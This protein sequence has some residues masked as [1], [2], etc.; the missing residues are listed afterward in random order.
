M[1]Y[2]I[3]NPNYTPPKPYPFII[4]YPIHHATLGTQAWRVLPCASINTILPCIPTYPYPSIAIPYPSTYL[5]LPTVGKISLP[6]LSI[7][8]STSH[9]RHLSLHRYKAETTYQIRPKRPRTGITHAETTLAETTQGWNDSGPK[10]PENAIAAVEQERTCRVVHLIIWLS[11]FVRVRIFWTSNIFVITVFSYTRDT[12]AVTGTEPGDEF[13][14]L[15][16]IEIN[17]AAFEPFNTT[18][19]IRDATEFWTSVIRCNDTRR[20]KLWPQVR[21]RYF[22]FLYY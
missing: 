1:L 12:G 18:Q 8:P 17:T 15:P 14:T 7:Y 9:P 20:V 2:T 19:C 6:T 5:T 13:Y 11:I 3:P 16:L 4:T 10:R 21:R 22:T